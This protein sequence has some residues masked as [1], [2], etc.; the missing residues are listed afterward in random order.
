MIFEQV[1]YSRLRFGDGSELGF[2]SVCGVVCHEHRF[3]LWIA[4]AYGLPCVVELV[5]YDSILSIDN[6]CNVPAVFESNLPARCLCRAGFFNNGGSLAAA[7]VGIGYAVSGGFF[8]FCS[9]CF[10]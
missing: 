4:D 2:C 10:E 7:G 6:I 8:A 3:T 1:E 9:R 5:C